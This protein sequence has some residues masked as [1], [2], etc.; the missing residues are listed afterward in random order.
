[1][2]H[3]PKKSVPGEWF[4]L[5]GLILNSFT[6]SLLI[7]GNFGIS[8]LSSLPYVISLAFPIFSNGIWNAIIQ[9]FWLIFT[10]IAIRKVKPS[11]LLSFVLAF[12]FGFLIDRFS[13]LML[14]WSSVL[15]A[16]IFYFSAGFFIMSLGISCFM[17]CGLPLLPFDTVVRAFMMEK[18]MGMR[19]AKT[20]FDLINVVLSILISLTFLGYLAGVGIGT[21]ISALVMGT[22][23][24]GITKWLKARLDIKPRLAWLGKLI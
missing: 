4:L 9:S 18:G 11:Y 7:K 12:I 22:F 21:I 6:T 15:A 19:K 13:D 16:R 20:G 17:I 2:A 8:A 5:F 10:M 23:V 3:T 24:S 14:G 1:M